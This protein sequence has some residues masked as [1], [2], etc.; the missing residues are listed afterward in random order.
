[1]RLTRRTNNTTATTNA[2]VLATTVINN[3]YS[4][5]GKRIASIPVALMAIDDSYQRVLGTTIKKLMN[6]WDNNKCDFLV[7]SYRDNKFY[8][9]D[10]QHR[11]SVAKAKGIV[12]PDIKRK[13]GITMSQK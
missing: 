8:V 3:S 6:S 5:C 9:I 7:V 11:Y 1:M 10:G 12:M 13:R 2:T 4:I